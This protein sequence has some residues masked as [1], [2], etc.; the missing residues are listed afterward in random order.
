MLCW[1]TVCKSPLFNVNTVYF[2]LFIGSSRNLEKVRKGLCR[3]T[4]TRYDN[5]DHYRVA[6]LFYPGVGLALPE[7]E[8]WW[9]IVG[10]PAPLVLQIYMIS[11]VPDS[12]ILAAMG[13]RRGCVRTSKRFHNS[14]LSEKRVMKTFGRV[15]HFDSHRS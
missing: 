10:L 13:I 15:K 4:L 5:K 11:Q 1:T 12:S 9:S 7:Y 8:Q 3:G 14:L 6:L 2:L